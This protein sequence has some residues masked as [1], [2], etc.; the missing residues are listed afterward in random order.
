MSERPIT[1]CY[2]I[3]TFI[4]CNKLKSFWSPLYQWNKIKMT[5]SGSV[6]VS[7]LSCTRTKRSVTMSWLLTI[8]GSY[9]WPKNLV[10]SKCDWPENLTE[11]I[12]LSQCLWPRSSSM[13]FRCGGVNWVS[14]ETSQV[15]L[16]SEKRWYTPPSLPVLDLHDPKLVNHKSPRSPWHPSHLYLI[17]GTT[18]LSCRRNQC[19][20]LGHVH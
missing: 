18:N 1:I 13:D 14:C 10:T 11:F 17:S 8:L 3:Y 5:K 20:L 6:S 12:S 15:R 19:T 7:T 16:R 4:R 2:P 9:I